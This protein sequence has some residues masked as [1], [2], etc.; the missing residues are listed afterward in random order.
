VGGFGDRI[1]LEVRKVMK[2]EWLRWSDIL[3]GLL[4]LKFLRGQIGRQIYV[5]REV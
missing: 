5:V 2:F 1:V 4:R 3:G